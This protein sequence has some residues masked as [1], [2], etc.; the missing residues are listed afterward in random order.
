VRKLQLLLWPAGAA[1]GIAAEWVYFGWGEPGDWLPDLAVGWTLIAC[2]LFAWSWRPKSLSGSLMAATG[3]AWFAANFTSQALYLHRGPLVHL[4]L[5]FPDGRLRGPL[6][7]AAVGIA[8]LLAV[9]PAV[10]RSEEATLAL[11][12]LLVAVA[13]QGYIRALGRERR[14]RLAAL[15]ATGFVAAV[16]AATAAA[17]LAF[18]TQEATDGTLLAY[19]AALCML[20]IGMLAALAR[21][22]W[23][24][25]G[26]TDLVVELGE[27]RSGTLRDGLARALGD[28]TLEVGYWLPAAGVY[29]DASGR[30]LDV[31]SPAPG[32][33]VTPIELDGQRI[34][35]LVHDAAVLDD[36]G[37]LDAVAAAT[38]LAA[39]NA[40]LQAEVRAQVAELTASRL[41]LVQAGD[42]ER[43]R[44][45][46]RLHDSAERRL[47]DLAGELG[48][49]HRPASTAEALERVRRAEE[50]LALTLDELRQLAAGLH[51]RVLGE[52]GLAG[53]LAA[54]AEQ[55]P[56]PVDVTA[57]DE[58]L[59]EEIEAA[60]YFVCSEALANVAKYASAS[61]VA[62]SVMARNGRVLVEVVDDGRGGAAIGGGTGLRGLADRVEALGGALRLDSPSG[63][64]TRIAVEL[65]LADEAR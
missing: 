21:E 36:R 47:T 51:P 60:A 4:V 33:R 25:A 46:Q 2:G 34:A 14:M 32:R 44:L 9:I 28:P 30:R 35:A 22:P 13:G 43:R 39:A 18:P 17:R 48:Q 3:F 12:A 6:D 57:P 27:V 45:E 5:S 10:W 15:Q 41:R 20:A 1:L 49:G 53:A 59:P 65:P 56:V 63:G 23:A 54:L 62:V 31:S 38:R 52:L 58:R 37:L 7:R 55:S 64:G 19:E 42:E 50:H 26:V 29:V 40:R 61:R 11:A 24:R 8:Y 16:L